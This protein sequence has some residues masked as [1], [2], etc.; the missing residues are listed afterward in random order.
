MDFGPVAYMK[1]PN[2]AVSLGLILYKLAWNVVLPLFTGLDILDKW[3][4]KI[5]NDG[6]LPSEWKVS[7]RL[8]RVSIERLSSNPSWH[9]CPTLWLHCASLGE[10]K[11]LWALVQA[12]ETPLQK[13]L[14]TPLRILMTANTAT[15]LDFLKGKSLAREKA[16]TLSSPVVEACIA[17][18]DH[19]IVVQNFLVSHGVKGLGLYESE[20]WPHYLQAC[21]AQGIPAFLVS[22]RISIRA[23]WWYEKFPKTCA[24]V[25][26]RLA[27]I[28]AQTV[29]DGKRFKSLGAGLVCP[30]F[31][32]KA[33]HY[34][35]TYVHAPAPI[36]KQGNELGQPRAR[37]GQPIKERLAL[38]SLHIQELRQLLPGLSKIMTQFDLL[39]FPRHLQELSLFRRLLQPYWTLE[40]FGIY[41]LKP[42]A[43]HILVD[44]MGRVEELLP[45][46]QLAFV[47]GSLIP[48]GCHNLWEPLLAGLKIYFGPY[49]SNQAGLAE[50]L[51]EKGIA[52]VLAQ[53][54]KIQNWR[55]PNA[56]LTKASQIFVEESR[57]A[58]AGA[59]EECRSRIFA[60]LGVSSGLVSVTFPLKENR[61]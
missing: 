27:W 1:K 23:Q 4:R 2:H 16:F 31:D 7:E 14:Q 54:G 43:R 55:G 30:G 13:P 21:E 3:T 33:A 53:G 22:A 25:L 51:L 50:P 12:L 42:N 37:V 9:E 15:G 57:G 19:P 45:S 11:G 41:S 38:V 18:F 39:I 61:L 6:F 58:L 49:Y 52:E 48:I 46:C 29:D 34:L 36:P 59:L 5:V 8:G 26:S 17:P 60:T 24:R 44:S 20:I 28:Q 40:G 56:E 35:Q 10:A 32:L 47:G